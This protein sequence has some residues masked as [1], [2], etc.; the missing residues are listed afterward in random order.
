MCV[1]GMAAQRST[2]VRTE[3]NWFELAPEG[4]VQAVE[5]VGVGGA[6]LFHIQNISILKMF[7]VCVCVRCSVR[8]KYFDKMWSCWERLGFATNTI[9]YFEIDIF[10]KLYCVILCSAFRYA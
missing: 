9:K 2:G 3:S 4:M 10:N 1:G 5:G 8:G 6:L 7:S